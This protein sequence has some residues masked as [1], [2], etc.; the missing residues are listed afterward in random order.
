MTEC[1]G[2][3]DPMDRWNHAEH[4]ER[5]DN[6]IFEKQQYLDLQSAKKAFMYITLGYESLSP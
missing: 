5:V 1:F 4:K 2:R 6:D 3:V